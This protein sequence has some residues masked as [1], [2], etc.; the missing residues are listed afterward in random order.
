MRSPAIE[1]ILGLAVD[2]FVRVRAVLALGHLA[3]SNRDPQDLAEA[4]QLN[5]VEPL[6]LP[7]GQLNGF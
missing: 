4:F 6:C 7:G 3:E 2:V 1:G 5:A